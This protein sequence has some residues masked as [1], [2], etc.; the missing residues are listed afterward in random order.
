METAEKFYTFLQVECDFK[1]KI[2]L[3]TPKII[4]ILNNIVFKAD[5]KFLIWSEISTGGKEH[6]FVS[7]R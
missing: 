5:Q 7:L 1:I 4:H 6:V 2:S 3:H